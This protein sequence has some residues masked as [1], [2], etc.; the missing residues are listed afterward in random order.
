MDYTAADCHTSL[1]MESTDTLIDLAC[2][3]VAALAESET[4]EETET[5]EPSP[6]APIS[7]LSLLDRKI[8]VVTTAALPWRTGTSVNP[9]ARALYLTRG[10]PRHHV[11]LLVPFLPSK[12]EQGQVFKDQVF[13]TEEEQE[14]WIR[15]YC[16]ERVHCKGMRK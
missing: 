4:K 14:K 11:T 2:N 16:D 5:D 8:W 12:V 10:R 1:A 13:E 15:T 9:M 7:D 3:G 6:I